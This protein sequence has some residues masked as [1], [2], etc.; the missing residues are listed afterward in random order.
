[1]GKQTSE[2]HVPK[3]RILPVFLF[4]LVILALA[5]SRM[6]EAAPTTGLC[7]KKVALDG[8]T[9]L[10][11]KTVGYQWLMN[12][13]NI[14]VLGDGETHYYHQGP[15][16]LDHPDPETKEML[17]WNPEED[18]NADTKDMGALKGTNLK[19]LCELVG[20]MTEGDKVSIRASDGL[21][22]TFSYKNV[23]LYSKREGPMVIAWYKNGQY[24]DTGFHD[25]MRLV[26]FADTS[27][28]P[29]GM[30]VFG[31]WDWHEAADAEYWY[32]YR[33]GDEKYPTTTGLSV[34]NV[35]EIVILSS[36]SPE[37]RVETPETPVAEF[38]ADVTSGLAPL[39][40]KFLDASE[41]SPQS[42]R[43]DFDNDGGEDSHSQNPSYTYEKPGLYSVRLIVS[44]SAGTNQVVKED[45]IEVI[46]A[47]SVGDAPTA[48][49]EQE[50]AQQGPVQQGPVQQQ[51][52]QPHKSLGEFLPFLIA[53]AV[54]VMAGVVLGL[55]IKC[56]R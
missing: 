9:V 8:S 25:G 15:V 53:A 18:I 16:F 28:N 43:W 54:L 35:S 11:E 47:P 10:D 12:P 30:N 33:T 21:T 31:N 4:A 3:G 46:Q 55:K 36:Q 13:D 19:D 52:D 26:W 40:V 27:T 44:N 50:Q 24:P 2:V 20:G 34:Q 32:Y 49:Q 38:H 7:I 14:P 42:W 23:Y 39:T 41:N 29:W 6:A 51:E 48:P 56:R 1:M 22:K 37:P 17:R 45:Y 5:L